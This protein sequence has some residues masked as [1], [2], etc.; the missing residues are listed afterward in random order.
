MDDLPHILVRSSVLKRQL[1]TWGATAQ[2]DGSRPGNTSPDVPGVPSVGPG[3]RHAECARR[4]R[5][6][7][8]SGCARGP[9]HPCTPPGR[10]ASPT[11]CSVRQ[12]SPMIWQPKRPPAEAGF[13]FSPW[14]N[15]TASRHNQGSPECVVIADTARPR[16]MRRYAL[17]CRNSLRVLP[18]AQSF[19]VLGTGGGVG[20]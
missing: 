9:A 1:S 11:A 13:S 15:S 3:V 14:T 5:R 6:R 12:A 17:S 16:C 10:Q 18:R 4:A 19:A 7:G 2:P 8:P 20:R